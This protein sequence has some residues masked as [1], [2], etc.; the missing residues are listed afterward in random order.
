MNT[1]PS[2]QVT[3]A[4]VW[5]GSQPLGQSAETVIGLGRQ[6]AVLVGTGQRQLPARVVRVVVFQPLAFVD[7]TPTGRYL[8]VVAVVL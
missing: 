3:V 4:L 2:S 5:S 8:L 1:V 6:L 7:T